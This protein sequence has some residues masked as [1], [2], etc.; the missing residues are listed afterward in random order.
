ME[1]G[2]IDPQEI[3]LVTFPFVSELAGASIASAAVTCTVVSGGEDPS[4]SDLLVG[5]AVAVGTNVTQRVKGGINGITYRLRAQV[6]DN[7]GNVH[8]IK[9]RM[10]V[11]D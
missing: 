5:S 7:V 11:K 10:L 6:T 2:P 4:P 1:I 3:K 8:V 9:T